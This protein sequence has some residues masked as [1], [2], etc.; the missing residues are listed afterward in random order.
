M[1]KW[2]F[3]IGG[4]IVLVGIGVIVYHLKPSS[5]A[6]NDRPVHVAPPVVNGEPSA[7]TAP[8]G[9]SVVRT[10]KNVPSPKKQQANIT[11]IVIQDTVTKADT[12]G[13]VHRDTIEV[14][15]NENPSEPPQIRIRGKG[16]MA[17]LFQP[18]RNP[19]CTT[20]I[21]YMAGVGADNEAHPTIAGMV[22]FVTFWDLI[23]LGGSVDF[24][25]LGPSGAVDIGRGWEACAKWNVLPFPGRSDSRATLSLQFMF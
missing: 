14:Y 10:N 9:P 25:G 15:G 5:N 21:H 16:G 13:T 6:T 7:V 1:S 4:I 17:I 20:E 22:S 3:L 23:R 8:V 2:L 11:T 18:I 19:W 24:F 12:A